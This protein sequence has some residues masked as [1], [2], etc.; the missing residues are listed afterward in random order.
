MKV[1]GI[2]KLEDLNKDVCKRFGEIIKDDEWLEEN[3]NYI[4]KSFRIRTNKYDN[5][6]YYQI[7]LLMIT[8]MKQL[9]GSGIVKKTETR[10]SNDKV[11]YYIYNNIYEQ[12]DIDFI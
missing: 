7:Y 9:F 4:K 2:L 8:V 10:I 11:F 5:K 3:F 1:L 6:E 12:S